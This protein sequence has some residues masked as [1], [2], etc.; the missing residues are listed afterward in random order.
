MATINGKAYSAANVQISMAGKVVAAATGI[1]YSENNEH[2]NIYVM[3]RAEPFSIVDNTTEYEGEVMLLLDEYEALQRSIPAGQSITK[4]AAFDIVVT[5]Q[6]R[7]GDIIT[8][9]LKNCRF[10]SLEKEWKAN[11]LFTEI[12]LPISIGSIAYNI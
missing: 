9:E 11:E 6:T 4:I 1:K 5:Y 8:D 7:L 10:K 2:T 12:A 3:G